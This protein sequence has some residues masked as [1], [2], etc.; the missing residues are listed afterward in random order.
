MRCYTHSLW[1]HTLIAY[2]NIVHSEPLN[3]VKTRTHSL[4]A[5]SGVAEDI[6]S[7]ESRC[8]SRK[9]LNSLPPSGGWKEFGELEFHSLQRVSVCVCVWMSVWEYYIALV[10][11]SPVFCGPRISTLQIHTSPYQHPH[12]PNFYLSTSDTITTWLQRGCQA[13]GTSFWVCVSP[14]L[15]MGQDAGFWHFK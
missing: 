4:S 1:D 13:G 12:T 6:E 10:P 15:F 7:A 9:P 14:A 2:L 11:L 8:D 3:H 5:G